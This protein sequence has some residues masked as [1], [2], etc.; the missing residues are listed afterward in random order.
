MV[1]RPELGSDPS[2]GSSQESG[3][4]KSSCQ[5]SPFNSSICLEIRESPTVSKSNEIRLG[6]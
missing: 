2:F 3:R 6:R 4:D 5:V 1:S